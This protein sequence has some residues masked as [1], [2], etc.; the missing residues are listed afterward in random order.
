MICLAQEAESQPAA[1]GPQEHD[2]PKSPDVV[3]AVE[4]STPK[5]LE[6][7]PIPADGPH[8]DGSENLVKE[9]EGTSCGNKTPQPRSPIFP[10]QS[11]PPPIRPK[12]VRRMRTTLCLISPLPRS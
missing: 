3:V 9:P 5:G 11:L 4:D 2:G 6:E 12:R 10:Q 1:E 8:D 7:I